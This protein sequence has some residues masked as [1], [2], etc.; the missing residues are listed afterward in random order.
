MAVATGCTADGSPVPATRTP[1]P[2]REPEGPDVALAATVLRDEQ[3]ILDQLVATVR[4]HPKVRPTVA[5]ARATH[6]AHVDLLTRAVP[7]DA[8]PPSGATT[9]RPGAVPADAAAALNSLARAEGELGAAVRRGALVADS[10]PFARLLASMAAAAG[11][12][13]VH[14][15]DAARERR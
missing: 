4:R 9:P 10:G 11:Q 5:G 13:S 1:A 6:R 2:T 15:S 14:L 3:A 7:R 8:P 12:Q